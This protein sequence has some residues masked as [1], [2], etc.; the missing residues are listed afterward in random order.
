[1]INLD[2][3][4]KPKSIAVVGVSRNPSKV[5]HVLYRNLIDGKF[6]GKIF[7]V[8]RKA[9]KILEKKSYKS[10]R[11]IKEK[12]D[13]AIIAVPAQYVPAI[14]KDCHKKD[15]RDL[16]IISS[17]FSEIGNTELEKG[18]KEYLT[19]NK[20]RMIG[21]NCLGI[22]D[23]HSKLDSIFLPRYKLERPL[24]GGISFVTQSGA[25]G[26][27]VLDL[28]AKRGYNF[29]KFVS[30]GNGTA[31]DES[32][33]IEYLGKD[34]QTKVICLYLEAVKDG[35]KFIKVMRE[36]SKKKPIIALKGG[37]TKEGNKAT[38]SHTGS[39]AGDA[40]VY[41]GVFKQVGVINADTIEEMLNFASIFEKSIKPD[42]NRVQVITNGG[43][44]GILCTDAISEN[45][46]LKLATLSKD[47]I[48]ILRLKFPDIVTVGNPMDLV[49]DAT[50]RRYKTAMEYCMRD[51]N[52]DILLVVALYQTPLLSADVVDVIAEYNDYKKKPIIVVSTGGEFTEVLREAL[53]KNNVVTFT[54]PKEA[55]KAIG[56]LVEY[57]IK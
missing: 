5:G 52:I 22:L 6:P 46:K 41:L 14:V 29:A 3:F 54:F 24:P 13:L 21:V 48:R 51:K 27:T 19:K 11:R 34:K 32:D 33:I 44:H 37:L 15:I 43:G 1:M 50:T 7:I 28:S 53:N 56:A 26:S 35:K 20:I 4:F 47:T 8:N 23:T 39:L 25:V 18:L 17:G 2:K 38:L 55:V 57:Y 42:S 40:E 31:I 45:S 36:V 16:I 30:Y 12:I 49:G 9:E 10:V